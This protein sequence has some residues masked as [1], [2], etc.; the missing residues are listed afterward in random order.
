MERDDEHAC[1]PFCDH[2]EPP[3]GC[4]C[5]GEALY[6]VKAKAGVDAVCGECR[7]FCT[8]ENEPC[9]KAHDP[10]CVWVYDGPGAFEDATRCN[11]CKRMAERAE[12]DR[13]AQEAFD[14]RQKRRD[15]YEAWCD[16]ENDRRKHEKEVA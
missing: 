2:D 3:R 12:E 13:Q 5:C 4:D 14:A 11:G 8:N 16:D 10:R 9:K 6:G 15:Q 1:H 7:Y